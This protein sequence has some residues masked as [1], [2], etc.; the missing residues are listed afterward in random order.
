V[1]Q[2]RFNRNYE[3]NIQL[4]PDRVVTITPPFR[5]AFDISKSVAGGLNNAA[6]SL[7]GLGSETRLALAKDVEDFSKAWG[8][9]FSLG[10]GDELRPV[11]KGSMLRGATKREGP[12]QVTEIEALD[13]GFDYLNGFTCR[14]VRGGADSVDSILQDMPNITRGKI[15]TLPTLSRP[16][17]MV[18]PS[19]RIIDELLGPSQ[20]WYIDDE[21]LHIIGADDVVSSYIPV[22]NAESGLLNTPERE[23][24]RVTLQT[25]FNPSLR[26]GGLFELRS[27]NAPHL[28]GVYKIDSMG[29]T[30]DTHGADWLQ[31]I[32]GLLLPEYKVI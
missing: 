5:L 16:R 3:L 19:A 26:I 7:S 10:Y 1:P 24:S 27:L 28:N 25:M 30:G 15:A 11:F 22:V 9:T 8:L 23:Q 17:V 4:S 21:Q 6:F 12:A 31:S 2:Y 14:T 29:Y 20:S 32:V 13:G 18:G